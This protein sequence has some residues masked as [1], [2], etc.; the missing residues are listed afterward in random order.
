VAQVV[1]YL[2]SKPKALSSNFSTLPQKSSKNSC[3]LKGDTT[4]HLPGCPKSKHGHTAKSWHSR[5]ESTVGGGAQSGGTLGSSRTESSAT[6]PWRSPKE[7]ETP[8]HTRT[9]AT[10]GHNSSIHNHHDL[11]ATEMS[12]GPGSVAQACHPSIR[13]VEAGRAPCSSKTLS[14]KKPQKPH[15]YTPAS[16]DGKQAL[17]SNN[18]S[19]LAQDCNKCH[20]GMQDASNSNLPGEQGARMRDDTW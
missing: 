16:P 13:E 5:S 8:V 2:P 4:A 11:E 20:P 17:V 18:V 10:D 7:V 14:Q 19:I 6:A 1:A 9:R 12:L 3:K 15:S